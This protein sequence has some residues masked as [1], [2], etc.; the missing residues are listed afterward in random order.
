MMTSWDIQN[1][2]LSALSSTV[3]LHVLNELSC[4]LGR[5][6]RAIIEVYASAWCAE[7]KIYQVLMIYLLECGLLAGWTHKRLVCYLSLIHI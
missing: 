1:V 5:I 6:F 3:S 7:Y 2:F 4:A